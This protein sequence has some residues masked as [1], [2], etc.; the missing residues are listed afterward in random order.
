M[1]R[2]N[3]DHFRAT[4]LSKGGAVDAMTLFKNFRGREPDIQPLLIKRGLTAE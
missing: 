2:A 1:T 3:G 4:L